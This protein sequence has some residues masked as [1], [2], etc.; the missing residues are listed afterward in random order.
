MPAPPK[1]SEAD[2]IAATRRL[3]EQRGRD[4][5]SMAEIAAAVGVRAPS[6]YLRF[7]D[8]AALLTA[9][10]LELWRELERALRG[11]ARSPD[12][13]RT[14]AAQARAYRAFARSNPQGYALMLDPGAERTQEGQRARAAAV[15]QTLP[16]F[17]ALVGPGEALS[18]A[19]VLTPF[20]HGFVSM[21]LAGAFRL[22][23]GIDEAFERG[24]AIILA[25]LGVP[26]GHRRRTV[27]SRSRG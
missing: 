5:F 27:R 26:G 14:L 20:L 25:G 22:G 24:V 19:R 6:L 10:Q 1:T 21:E 16:S 17:A 3:I 12:P 9:V 13:A 15:A 7:R 4:G 2:I 8:R 23:P 11:A 18:A